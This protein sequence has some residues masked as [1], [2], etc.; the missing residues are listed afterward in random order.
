ME[1]AHT[2]NTPRPEHPRGGGRPDSDISKPV[3][4][5]NDHSSRRDAP[6][7]PRR[8]LRQRDSDPARASAL[9]VSPTATA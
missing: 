9:A 1:Y 4:Q 7:L 8:G 3:A 2:L 6:L 5:D